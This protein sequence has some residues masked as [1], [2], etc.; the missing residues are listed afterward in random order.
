MPEEEVIRISEDDL[1]PENKSTALA[2]PITIRIDDEDIEV[3]Q[4]FAVTWRDILKAD[5]ESMI[6]YKEPVSDQ[7]TTEFRYGVLSNL[8][9]DIAIARS[10]SERTDRQIYRDLAI[11]Y[12]PDLYQNTDQEVKDLATEYTQ[13]LGALRQNG[14]LTIE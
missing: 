7:V 11:R 3:E 8:R 1:P 12:H 5:A 9:H 14:E 2:E 6:D 4:D 10:D 13:A